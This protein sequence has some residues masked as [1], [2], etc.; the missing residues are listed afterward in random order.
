MVLRQVA[1]TL[2]RPDRS[3]GAVHDASQPFP[4]RGL[5][6]ENASSELGDVLD[7]RHGGIAPW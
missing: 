7:A 3:S 2:Y 1:G 6:A 5:P 4:R